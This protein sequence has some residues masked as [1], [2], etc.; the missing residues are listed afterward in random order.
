[1]SV[2]STMSEAEEARAL[3]PPSDDPALSPPASP[4]APMSPITSRS[5]LTPRSRSNRRGG[6]SKPRF[7]WLHDWRKQMAK[8]FSP[9]WRRTV[10]LMWIIWGLMAFGG[11]TLPEPILTPAYTMFNVWLPSVLES[12]QGDGDNA[13]QAAL[14]EYVMY[15]AAGCPGSVVS[16]PNASS[17]RRH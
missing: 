17:V 7:A 9:R 15:A 12:R 8:L 16:V 2:M 6:R 13:I 1:M 11:F 4:M 5:P 10:I 3:I 14:K